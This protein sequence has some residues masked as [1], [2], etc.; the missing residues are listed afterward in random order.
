MF[1]PHQI[2]FIRF[3]L[4]PKTASSPVSCDLCPKWTN[5][6]V[7]LFL[8]K[9]LQPKL[10]SCGFLHMYSPYCYRFPTACHFVGLVI[11]WSKISMFNVQKQT[12]KPHDICSDPQLHDLIFT[13]INQTILHHPLPQ[14]LHQGS[15]AACPL[16]YRWSPCNKLAQ[17]SQLVLLQKSLF[18]FIPC[19]H[20]QEELV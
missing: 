11:E 17:K 18:S 15:A 20:P 1:V 5:W 13:S 9:T 16:T 19:F 10:F 7:F 3:A 4:I 6:F 2:F 8:F 12:F 14:I